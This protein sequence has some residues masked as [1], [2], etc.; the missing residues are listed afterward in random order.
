MVKYGLNRVQLPLWLQQSLIN[1]F[2]W[3]S[4]SWAMVVSEH[5]LCV[6]R[7]HGIIKSGGIVHLKSPAFFFF[8]FYMIFARQ[9]GLLTAH[10]LKREINTQ[11]SK[12]ER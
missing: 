3:Y 5:L 4:L 1:G 8:F 10:S 7:P 11:T 12:R 2:S 6:M 9:S